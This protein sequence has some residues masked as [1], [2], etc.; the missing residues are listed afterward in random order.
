MINLNI[1]YS[2]KQ[3]AQKYFSRFGLTLNFNWTEKVWQTDEKSLA[4]HNANKGNRCG[5]LDSWFTA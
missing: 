2:D 4:D 5:Y 1:K 3:T